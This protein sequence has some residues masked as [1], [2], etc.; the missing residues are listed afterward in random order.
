MNNSESYSIAF[1]GWNP[2]QFIQIKQLAASMPGSVF[3]IEKKKNNNV[4][5][6][7]EEILNNNEVPILIWEQKDMIKLDGVFDIVVAQTMFMH[8]HMF[9]KSKIV[10]LQYGYAKEVHNFGTWRA[11][12]DLT[13]T[14]GEYATKKISHFCPT[15]AVGN[16]RYDL[17]HEIYFHEKANKKYE[18]LL[19]KDKK[20]LLYMPTWGELSSVDIFLD[21][22]LELS[23][24]YN[25]LLKLHHNTDILEKNRVDIKKDDN[26]HYF[27]ATD[28]ALDL[29]SI[30]DIVISDYSGAIFDAIYCDKPV[31]LLD[32]PEKQLE[33]IDKIDEHSL[34]ISS[35]NELGYRV[36]A[37]MNLSDALEYVE[38][39]SNTILEKQNEIKE[40]LFLSEN[41]SVERA[42]KEIDALIE[43]KHITSQIQSYIKESVRE[44]Y[45]TKRSLAILKKKMKK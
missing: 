44:L 11:F 33:S 17:W 3:V 13:L 1:V 8:L 28:D 26:I 5:E 22:I 24:R 4:D 42:I 34:E 21:A 23:D 7:S 14:Y 37:S 30:S 32:L 19:N 10:M 45:V 29:L 31:I 35:R 18:K 20:T 12:A 2:F 36:N 38:K 43:G 40:K 6:F 41:N 16:P 15:V 39:N 25:V 9:Q 27:G